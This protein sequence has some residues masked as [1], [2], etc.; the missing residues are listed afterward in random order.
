MI[1]ATW[2]TITCP[3]EE[4][5]RNLSGI[6]MHVRDGASCVS[7]FGRWFFDEDGEANLVFSGKLITFE[8]GIRFF[9]Y[10]R[11][12]NRGASPKL[13]PGSLKMIADLS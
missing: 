8:Q 9:D 6:T 2:R 4:D 3:M 12:G 5:E 1:L 13:H 10:S 7:G 11:L